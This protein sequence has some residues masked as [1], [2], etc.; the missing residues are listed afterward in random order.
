MDVKATYTQSGG[1]FYP[2]IIRNGRKETSWEVPFISKKTALKYA[3]IWV[4][5]L[6]ITPIL[7]AIG[8]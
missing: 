4:N 6:R 8:H 1:N 7:N 3:Q 2:A 5:D